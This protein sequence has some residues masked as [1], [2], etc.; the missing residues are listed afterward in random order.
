M[1]LVVLLLVI[2]SLSITVHYLRVKLYEAEVHGVQLV[3]K[4]MP[5]YRK[6]LEN[7][8]CQQ[9]ELYKRM[10][11][12]KQVQMP[13]NAIARSLTMMKLAQESKSQQSMDFSSTSEY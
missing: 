3:E 4:Q 12:S 2:I 9:S 13:V 10:A 5:E 7:N 6:M 8:R 1:I 11:Q